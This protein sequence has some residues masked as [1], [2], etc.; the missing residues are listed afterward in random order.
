MRSGTKAGGGAFIGKLHLGL[1]NEASLRRSHPGLTRITPAG[2]FRRG[3]ELVSDL[4]GFRLDGQGLRRGHK[5]V[6]A[7]EEEDIYAALGLPFIAPELREGRGA[8][9]SSSACRPVMS[10][11]RVSGWL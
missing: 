6:A 8:A 4:L 3:C 11:L 5:I 1:N 7:K 2:N 10:V 9:A